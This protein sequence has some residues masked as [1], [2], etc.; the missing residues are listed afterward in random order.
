MVSDLLNI[1]LSTTLE[2]ILTAKQYSRM[3]SKLA[4]S[5]IKF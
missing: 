5:Q 2:Q 4:F 3:R 1:L